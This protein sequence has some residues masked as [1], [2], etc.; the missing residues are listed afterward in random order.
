MTDDTKRPKFPKKSKVE[1]NLNSVK[2]ADKILALM[3]S[4]EDYYSDIEEVN[5]IVAPDTPND[6]SEFLDNTNPTTILTLEDQ[7]TQQINSK[8][9]NNSSSVFMNSSCDDSFCSDS[10]YLHLIEEI[11]K[12]AAASTQVKKSFFILMERWG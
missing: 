11:E 12:N 4:M 2:P 1:N 5:H 7:T 10:E 6:K 9:E 3:D 8:N